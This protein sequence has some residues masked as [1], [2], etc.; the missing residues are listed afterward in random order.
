MIFF[1]SKVSLGFSFGD[2]F[3]LSAWGLGGL[4]IVEPGP[5]MV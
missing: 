3:Y 2:T 1:F 4:T 5:G